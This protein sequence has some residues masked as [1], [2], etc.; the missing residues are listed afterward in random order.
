MELF[1]FAI[2][3]WPEMFEPNLDNI[4]N[5]VRWFKIKNSVP[6]DLI[7]EM[8]PDDAQKF[9]NHLND[10]IICKADLE[11]PM[12]SLNRHAGTFVNIKSIYMYMGVRIYITHKTE[13]RNEN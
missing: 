11:A 1:Q 12:H 5:V 3:E 6:A 4:G 2:F 8:T 7:I 10:N 9:S 13:I